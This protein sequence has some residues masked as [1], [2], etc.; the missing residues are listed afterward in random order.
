MKWTCKTKT[1]VRYLPFFKKKPLPSPDEGPLL[2]AARRADLEKRKAFRLEMFYL[3]I[4]ETFL[5]TEV[6]L[7]PVEY[8]AQLPHK[9]PR[10]RHR[11]EQ[12][13]CPSAGGLGMARV[14]KMVARMP[15]VTMTAM[16]AHPM[17]AMWSPNSSRLQING[18]AAALTLDNLVVGG[19][20]GLL[21]LAPPKFICWMRLWRAISI[22]C[23]TTYAHLKMVSKRRRARSTHCC[24]VANAAS[25][26]RQKR[27]P[28]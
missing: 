5:S 28:R 10:H 4:R 15:L 22:F 14:R 17:G 1:P 21:N 19:S 20:W 27:Y 18:G 26:S 7:Q 8:T 11:C 9:S 13:Q 6:D 3:S 25:S 16:P 2:D 12:V 23:S 24:A